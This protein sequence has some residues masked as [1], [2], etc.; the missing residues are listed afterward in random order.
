MSERRI[1]SGALG[2]SKAGFKSRLGKL[3]P[4][5]AWRRKRK[6]F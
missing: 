4:A 6:G 1:Y 3:T 2:T 5:L